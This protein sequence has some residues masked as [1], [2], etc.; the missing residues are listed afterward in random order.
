[1][2]LEIKHT[3]NNCEGNALSELKNCKQSSAAKGCLKAIM[4]G[5]Y[6]ML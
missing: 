3:M 5:S 2:S 6:E 1:M 4:E